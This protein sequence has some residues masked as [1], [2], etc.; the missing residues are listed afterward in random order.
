MMPGPC[1]SFALRPILSKLSSRPRATADDNTP[2]LPRR[3]PLRS[4]PRPES[5]ANPKPPTS[6]LPPNPSSLLLRTFLPLPPARPTRPALSSATPSILMSPSRS[7]PLLSTL[8]T[9]TLLPNP[10]TSPLPPTP[11]LN[12]LLLSTRA[13]KLRRPTLRLLTP[14]P[15]LLTRRLRRMAP[16]A[17]V[18]TTFHLRVR[19]WFDGSRSLG[20]RPSSSFRP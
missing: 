4:P 16:T 5:R 1:R 13:P 18:T 15:P 6:L 3:S 10:L 12:T 9:S 20:Q 8:S 11:P 2:S 14:G 7:P 17:R 19:R